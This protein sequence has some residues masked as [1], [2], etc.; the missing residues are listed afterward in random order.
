MQHL[1]RGAATCR[2][3]RSRCGAGGQAL[4]EFALIL[5]VFAV[6]LFGIIQFGITFGGHTALSNVAREVA[7]YASTAPPNSN[8]NAQ[9]ASAARR[10]IP[11]YNNTATLVGPTYCWYTNPGTPV[12]YSWRVTVT[13]RYGHPIFIPL[14]GA[15]LDRI[16]GTVDNRFTTSVREEMRVETP[17]LA[18]APTGT[19]CNPE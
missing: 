11:A 6:L 10:Y 17:P 5:P 16:D 13:I 7:R 9:V 15:F 8:L 12:T 3:P 1:V 19:Q 2:T 18:V 4:S 14:V